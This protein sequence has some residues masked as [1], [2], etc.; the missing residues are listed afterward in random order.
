MTPYLA[1]RLTEKFPQ[2]PDVDLG[3]DAMEPHQM[4]VLQPNEMLDSVFIVLPRALK[5]V[6][7]FIHC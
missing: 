7:V 2:S 4:L 1:L 5:K 3:E 6:Q